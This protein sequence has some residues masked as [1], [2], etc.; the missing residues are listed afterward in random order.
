MPQSRRL[1]CWLAPVWSACR[2]LRTA[3]NPGGLWGS[4]WRCLAWNSLTRSPP[5]TLSGTRCTRSSASPLQLAYAATSHLSFPMQLASA[6]LD[7]LIAFL[8]HGGKTALRA[9]VTPSSEPFSNMVLSVG[10]DIG[11]VSLSWI[12]VQHPYFAAGVV[13]VL[14]IVILLLMRRVVRGLRRL[15]RSGRKLS[16]ATE[17]KGIARSTTSC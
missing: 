10:E 5:S 15:F 8:A 1:A 2:P 11:A 9:V 7:G 16:Q 12:A 6:V 14:L 3:C 4:R 13:A 17:G